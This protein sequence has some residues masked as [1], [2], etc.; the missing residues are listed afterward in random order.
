MQ[1]GVILMGTISLLFILIILFVYISIFK[2][3]LSILAIACL[4]QKSSWKAF[5]VSFSLWYLQ[6]VDIM[7]CNCAFIFFIIVTCGIRVLLYLWLFREVQ[8]SYNIICTI[9]SISLIVCLLCLLTL[10][11]SKCCCALYFCP[12]SFVTC[13]W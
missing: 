11:V 4:I 12:V 8:I 5:N 3:L 1:H 10:S 13:G 2:R 9:V 6:C 7:F